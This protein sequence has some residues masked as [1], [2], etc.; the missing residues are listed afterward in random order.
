MNA[1]LM[2]W[3]KTPAGWSDVNVWEVKGKGLNKYFNIQS[4]QK[5]AAVVATVKTI[6]TFK[7]RQRNSSK[8]SQTD[9]CMAVQ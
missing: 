3:V 7:I 6:T 8:W 1:S 4:A 9:I 5:K 2:L